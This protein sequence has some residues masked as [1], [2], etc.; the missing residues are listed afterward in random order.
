MNR[1]DDNPYQSPQRSDQAAFAASVTKPRTWWPYPL[2]VCISLISMLPPFI[3]VGLPCAVIALIVVNKLWEKNQD[4][5]PVLAAGDATDESKIKFKRF[6]W[7][8]IPG[9]IVAGVAVFGGTC[10]PVAYGIL[11]LDRSSLDISEV[12]DRSL[13]WGISLGVG[14][15]IATIVYMI[16]QIYSHRPR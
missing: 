3:V 2:I 11:F 6:A 16:Q 8:M 12:L 5:R 1:L 7:I 13:F 14:A 15:G 4:P 9:S 10:T